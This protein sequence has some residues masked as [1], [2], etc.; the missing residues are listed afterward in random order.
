VSFSL[1]FPCLFCVPFPH[2]F[3][4]VF[5]P[6]F[7]VN[8]K[9]LVQADHSQS[10]FFFSLEEM[11]V[12]S[13]DVSMDIDPDT[14]SRQRKYPAIR[15]YYQASCTDPSRPIQ[16]QHGLSN[17]SN[18]VLGD[19]RISV[20]ES[21]LSASYRLSIEDK[22]IIDSPSKSK[23]KHYRRREYQEAHDKVGDA[24]INRLE[25]VMKDKLL[26]RNHLISSPVHV[27][28]AFK[29]F[30]RE[31]VMRI[32]IEGF[33]RALEFLGF[34][35]SEIQNLA[36]FARYDPDCTG[37]IDYMN[38]INTA[39]FYDPR[40]E[41]QPSRNSVSK[42]SR[43]S[44]TQEDLYEVPDIDDNDLRVLQETELRRLFGK[45]DVNRSGN[46]NKDQFELLLMASGQNVTASDVDAIF[47]DLGIPAGGLMSFDQFFGVMSS[48][49]TSLRRK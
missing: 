48:S 33:T 4:R 41:A 26:Q 46:I 38:F 30:D 15:D 27:R 8:E 21:I 31:Q 43:E 6:S 32:H 3:S 34:Q 23:N 36:L 11:S 47:D 29:F 1:S 25:K 2:L 16:L 14:S 42:S 20:N 49:S 12:L 13:R 45:I 24:E 44:K 35:F 17:Y 28:K 40:E 10:F 37:E 18:L 39:M 5:S 19:D 22:L 9:A 7:S